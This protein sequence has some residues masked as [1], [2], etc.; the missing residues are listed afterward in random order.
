[1]ATV[2]KNS[3]SFGNLQLYSSVVVMSGAGNE[4][5]LRNGLMEAEQT[6]AGMYYFVPY[7]LLRAGNDIHEVVIVTLNGSVSFITKRKLG[8]GGISVAFAFY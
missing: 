3:V 6:C 7:L 2:S 1:V 8:Q 5:Y 4:I